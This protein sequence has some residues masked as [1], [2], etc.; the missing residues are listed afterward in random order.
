MSYESEQALGVADGQGSLVC[1]SPWSC[2]ESDM[3]ERLNWTELKSESGFVT[4]SSH[5]RGR[6]WQFTP[7]LLPGKSTGE[8]SLVGYS[9]WCCK[10]SDTTQHARNASH[11]D[12]LFSPLS[13]LTTLEFWQLSLPHLLSENQHTLQVPPPLTV[14]SLK[15][16]TFVGISDPVTHSGFSNLV[17]CHN[18]WRR[19]KKT[20]KTQP[21]AIKSTFMGVKH[22]H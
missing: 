22:R 3:T 19:L 5:H 11:H 7:V 13:T 8:G 14:I 12:H 18:G 21:R 17:V 2:K 16:I 15:V 4:H 9:P 20:N 10:E 6:K 1:C